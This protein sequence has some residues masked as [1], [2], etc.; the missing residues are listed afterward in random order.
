MATAVEGV[1]LLERNLW[2]RT[3]ASHEGGTA[4]E[5]RTSN[6][7]WELSTLVHD[8]VDSRGVVDEVLSESLKSELLSIVLDERL[9]DASDLVSAGPAETLWSAL[10]EI[11]AFQ[12]VGGW[13]SHD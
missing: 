8:D 11:A 1:E 7:L 3:L 6:V 9:E 2:L 5:C 4:V 13:N 10:L 12:L